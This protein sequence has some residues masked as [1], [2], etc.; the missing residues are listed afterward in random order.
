MKATHVVLR[1]QQLE[2]ERRATLTNAERM[3][4]DGE[5]GEILHKEYGDGHGEIAN[6]AKDVFEA[7]YLAGTPVESDG[8]LSGTITVVVTWKPS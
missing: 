8:R 1:E 2:D 6:L 5:P 7:I 3:R 4:E